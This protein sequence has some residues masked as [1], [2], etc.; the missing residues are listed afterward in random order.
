MIAARAPQAEPVVLGEPEPAWRWPVD[1]E[2]DDR[3]PALSSD[4]AVAL[5]QLVRELDRGCPWPAQLTPVLGRLFRPVENALTATG[6]TGQVRTT[7][8][9]QIAREMQRRQ[10]TPGA[11]S[12]DQWVETLGATER[13]FRE[14]HRG[15][16]ESRQHLIALAYL[17]GG[18]QDW[19]ALG[20]NNRIELARKIFGQERVD[21]ALGRVLEILTRLG[22]RPKVEERIRVALCEALLINRSPRLADL[23]IN[24]LEELRARGRP[25][26]A[27]QATGW[28]VLSQALGILGF[29]ERP[30]PPDVRRDQGAPEAPEIIAPEWVQWCARWRDTSPLPPPTRS[31]Y[32]RLLL[33]AGR[34]VTATHPNVTGPAEWTRE[35]AAAYVA[36]VDRMVV[37][38]YGREPGHVRGQGEKPLSA[39]TKESRLTAMRAFFRDCQEWGWIVRRF[40]PRRCFAT[41]RAIL[42]L[43]APNPRVIADDVWA[44]LLWAG[45]NLNEADLLAPVSGPRGSYPFALVRAV[46]VVWL[47][48]G[49]RRNEIRRLRVGCIRWQGNDGAPTGSEADTARTEICLLEVPPHKTGP[50]FTKPVDRLIGEAISGW[51][52]ER[53]DQPPLLDPKTGEPV[54]YLFAYRGRRI[55]MQFLNETLIPVL[56][57]KAGVPDRDARGAI[58]SHRA[59][60]TIA[61]QLFNAREPLSLFELQAWLGHRSPNS[62]Q[63]YAKLSPTTLAKAYAAADYFARN[64]RAVEVLIDQESIKSGAATQQPWKF[65]DLGHGY[66]SYDFFD[67]CPHRMACAKCAFYV[68]KGS[69]RAQVLEGRANLLRMLQEIP[70]TEDERAAVDDGVAAFDRLLTRLADLPTPD[71]LTPRQLARRETIPLGVVPTRTDEATW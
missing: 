24:L 19:S 16:P 37:G 38:Q 47:F 41:P 51:E 44:K 34:W 60:A 52:Q 65:Y 27:G 6:A 39:Q 46:T 61:T 55:G 26:H 29:L 50:A 30:L 17:I 49:L 48:G 15:R 2:Q 31:A 25:R 8:L 64:I 70:L 53:P 43:L 13:H 18:F 69:S 5:A 71:G 67:Q 56:C 40:D 63:H 12:S 57:H 59:R 4:E 3:D 66:C 23:T 22:Y 11:W 9:R 35:I 28:S 36:A 14:R 1:L 45:L 7:A 10:R 54:S 20:M 68:P 58:T 33:Q 62:T 21:A 32:Y 42:A